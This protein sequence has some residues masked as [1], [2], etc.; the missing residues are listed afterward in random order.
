MDQSNGKVRA[1]VAHDKLV[2]LGYTGSERTTRRAVADGQE[3]LQARPAP[4]LPALGARTG[5]VVPVRLGR[6]PAGGWGDEDLAVLRLAGLEPFPG[7]DPGHRQ[8]AADV[9]RLH[10][11]D[12]APVRWRAHLRAHRQRAHGDYRPCGPHP[13]PPSAFGRPRTHYGLTV[14]TC[15]VRDPQSKGGSEATVRVAA[16]DL[17]PTE[18]NLLPGLHDLRRAEQACGAFSAQVNGRVHR[19][20]GGSRSRCWPRSAPLHRLPARPFTACFGVTRTVGANM[21]VISFEGVRLLGAPRVGARGGL[22]ASPRRRGDH[23]PRSATTGRKRWPA[24]SGEAPGNPHYVDEHF[25]PTPEGPLHRTPRPR[26]RRSAFLASGAGAALWLTEAGRGRDGATPGEDGRRRRLAALHGTATVDRAL[27]EAA[28]LG[29]FAEGDL[30]SIVAHQATGWTANHAGPV[31][32]TRCS[33]GPPRGTG[34]DDE[35]HPT[36]AT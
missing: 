6:R 12:A 33:P 24:T 21:P 1:D 14:A 2:A 27:A 8:D 32:T 3:G 15:V 25:G 28:V 22:G 34:S 13:H 20:P 10:R 29:R 23:R 17:V 26:T 11:P 18:A 5:H 9:Y 36:G 4:G 7:G 35:G 30:A 16:A 19:A 31:R